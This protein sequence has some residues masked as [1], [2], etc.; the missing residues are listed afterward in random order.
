M[1]FQLN[2]LFG[3]FVH[4]SKAFV[5]FFAG[6]EQDLNEFMLFYVYNRHSVDMHAMFCHPYAKDKNGIHMI[7]WVHKIDVCINYLSLSLSRLRTCFPVIFPCC[8]SVPIFNGN[9]LIFAKFFFRFQIAFSR[10]LSLRL[11]I[12]F[13]VAVVG[14]R[15][16]KKCS[17]EKKERKIN[18]KSMGWEH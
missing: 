18:G 5:G 2:P 14:F 16:F 12:I 10:S 6:L 4:R 9:I 15:Q 7:D 17:A 3:L 13:I 11:N 8:M 1:N